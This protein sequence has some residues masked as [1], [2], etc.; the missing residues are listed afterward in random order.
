MEGVVA[1]HGEASGEG[2]GATVVR[3]DERER[4]AFPFSENNYII[5]KQRERPH[6]PKNA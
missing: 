2:E 3:R 5:R 1:D 4:K 6:V